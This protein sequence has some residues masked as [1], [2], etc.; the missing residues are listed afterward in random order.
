MVLYLEPAW[1]NSFVEGR[2][3]AKHE[4]V[5]TQMRCFSKFTLTDRSP[6]SMAMGRS[7]K[8]I[9][10]QISGASSG[11]RSFALAL[12]AMTRINFPRQTRVSDVARSLARSFRAI[13]R[14]VD[15]SRIGGRTVGGLIASSACSFTSDNVIEAHAKLPDRGCQVVTLGVAVQ[16]SPAE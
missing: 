2:A 6:Q 10:N 3:E 12:I 11:Y 4:Q 16:Q 9:G 5:Q 7:A 15:S 8:A 14:L 13:S 1:S